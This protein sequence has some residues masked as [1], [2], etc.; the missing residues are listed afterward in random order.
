MERDEFPLSRQ[1]KD[2]F[3]FS[4][5]V[6]QLSQHQW[7]ETGQLHSLWIRLWSYRK[8]KTVNEVICRY[9]VYVVFN[10]AFLKGAFNLFMYRIYIPFFRPNKATK[11]SKNLKGKLYQIHQIKLKPK[12]K[13]AYKS[14]LKMNHSRERLLRERTKKKSIFKL[15]ENNDT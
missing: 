3:P 6:D 13:Q 14:V 2:A 11:V 7:K 12:L 8:L 15:A 4:W 5:W 10:C 9:S 1:G